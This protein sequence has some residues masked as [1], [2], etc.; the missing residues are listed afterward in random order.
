[1]DR[2]VSAGRKSRNDTMPPVPPAERSLLRSGTMTTLSF[3]SLDSCVSTSKVRRLS[4][5]SPKKSMRKGYS[6]EKEKTSMILPRTAY[7]PGS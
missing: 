1:M 3:F 5:S 4:T 7:W 2:M 6:L